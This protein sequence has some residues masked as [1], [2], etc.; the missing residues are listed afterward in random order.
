MAYW[1]D[2][3][4]K[5]RVGDSPSNFALFCKEH[6]FNKG[7]HIVEFGCGNG[8]DAIFFAQHDINVF[9]I[10][11]C[12]EEITYLQ[13]T[14]A[15]ETLQFATGDFSTFP[16]P[17][18][19]YNAIYSRFSLH[20]ITQT[21]ENNALHIAYA[22]LVSGGYLCIEA[23]GLSNEYYG[24][25]KALSE[26]HAFFYEGHYRRFI[27]IHNLCNTLTHIGFTLLCADEAKG[28]AYYN[29]IDHTFLRV[30]AVK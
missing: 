16:L 6:Y 28:R 27:D 24:K 4:S 11:Q 8:R 26:Q 7:D 25:G 1:E 23:R 19:Y 9:A 3:Y 12:N 21:Q 30:L 29:G 18:H 2:F 22:S 5:H 14:Y 13:E 10:D 20:S 17:P 15:S